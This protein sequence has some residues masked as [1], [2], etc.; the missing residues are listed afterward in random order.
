MSG[1]MYF[2]KVTPQPTLQNLGTAVFVPD[3]SGMQTVGRH[4]K[5]YISRNNA[6]LQVRNFSD[7]QDF[8]SS[9]PQ[10]SSKNELLSSNA[11]MATHNQFC[12]VSTKSL[13]LLGRPESGIGTTRNGTIRR[14]YLKTGSA[15]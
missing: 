4:N 7:N 5:V 10:L 3:I 12:L 15:T 2:E 6:V 1:L 14:V 9:L 11:G 8:F 13:L